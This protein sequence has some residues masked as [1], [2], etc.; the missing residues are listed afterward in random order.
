MVDL[1]LLAGWMV[2]EVASAAASTAFVQPRRRVAWFTGVA[3]HVVPATWYLVIEAAPWWRSMP[4]PAW[5]PAVTLGLCGA[6]LQLAAGWTGSGISQILD[7]T[8]PDDQ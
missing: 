1:G 7:Q 8:D 6:C 2:G 4:G 3:A 5:A